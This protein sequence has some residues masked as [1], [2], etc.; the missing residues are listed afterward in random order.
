MKIANSQEE[1][2][3]FKATLRPLLKAFIAFCEEYHLTWYCAYGTAIGVARHQGFIP[4]DDDIDVYMPRE[5]YNRFLSL[6]TSLKDTDYEIID[7]EDKGYYLYFAK[8]CNRNSTLIEREGERPIGI[9]IDVFTLDYYHPEYSRPLQKHN[10]FYR[11]AWI[12]YA[13]GIRRHSWHA[14]AQSIWQGRVGRVGLIA[15]D[16]I[17]FRLFT[18]PAKQIIKKF[19]KY[20]VNTPKS[21]KMWQYNIINFYSNKVYDAA[22]FDHGVEMTFEDF[23]VMMPCGYDSYLTLQYGNYMQLPPEDKRVPHH[24]HLF[25]DFERRL[26]D[27]EIKELNNS[28]P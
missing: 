18:W 27:R 21:D 12:V 22:W 24:N 3:R 28:N 15:L 26:T 6:K 8:F 4:W 7:W 25:V 13:H 20:L 5:D 14:F 19:L 1:C 16:A 17:V 11:N 9:Y 10:T 23:T 2:E